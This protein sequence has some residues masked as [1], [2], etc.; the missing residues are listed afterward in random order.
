MEMKDGLR[1]TD[2][3]LR[4][5][6]IFLSTF[7]SV[8]FCFA[9]AIKAQDWKKIDRGLEYTKIEN[10]HAFKI[11]P[12]HFRLSV[13]TAPELGGKTAVVKE[14]AKHQ[15][16]ILA[17]NGG[18]FSQERK[19]I[20]LLMR[21]GKKINPLHETHWWAIFYV[22]DKQA[23]IVPP[24]VFQDH[25]KI[26]MALQAGP[27]LLVQ[28]VI[29]KL[30][31]A[32]PRPRSGIGIQKKG[33]VILAITTEEAG[34]TIQAFAEL[35]QKLDCVNALNLDGGSSSQLYIDWKD[36]KLDLP[37]PSPVTNAITLFPRY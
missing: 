13:V 37:G 35:F 7:L 32:E 31:P 30:K 12:K 8:L 2:H 10:I 34:M 16:A 24:N 18:F 26:E 14:L 9:P 6:R 19:S 4:T 23:V 28:G 21:D 20:G 36:F 33:D 11:N 5:R 29:P 22:L 17:I 15:K 3:G 1:T 27:R 25:P